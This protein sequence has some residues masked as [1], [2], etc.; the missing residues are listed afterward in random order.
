MDSPNSVKHIAI[1]VFGVW[2]HT[3]PATGFAVHLIEACK[4]VTITLLTFGSMFDK[5]LNELKKLGTP[6]QALVSR[7]NVIDISGTD[8]NFSG[9]Q[10][11][12]EPV[13]KTLW[14][15]GSVT[16]LSSGKTI[17]GLPKPCLTILGVS[18]IQ[19]L[20][21]A[22]RIAGK[23]YPILLWMP[24]TARMMLRW[25]GP[26][27]LGGMGNLSEK[28]KA[29]ASM[30][31]ATLIDAAVENYYSTEEKVVQVP[32]MPAMYAYEFLATQTT[33]APREFLVKII[34][35]NQG[36]FADVQGVVCNTASVLERD[37]IVSLSNWCKE[38][39]IGF[40]PI[41]PMLCQPG[42]SNRAVG[43]QAAD[44]VFYFLD[45]MRSRFGDKSVIYISFGS[46]FWPSQPEKFWNAID[47]LISSGTPFVLAYSGMLADVSEQRKQMI[48][49]SQFGF[50]LQWAPQ[51]EILSHPATGWFLN[52][53][54]WN[55]I[56][57]TVLAG[58]PLILWP[59]DGDQ[60]SNAAAMSLLQ[61][62]AIE[63]VEVR[64][65][66]SGMKTPYRFVAP[67]Y[68]K[69]LERQGYTSAPT[70]T[71]EASR[72]EFRRVL[73]LVK[74]E[75]GQILREN[76][77]KLSNEMRSLWSP[78]GESRIMLNEIIQTYL[79]L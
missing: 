23:E 75:E 76:M 39:G 14:S 4:D 78:E 56:Q 36:V 72:Q 58:V 52:H 65:S 6:Q 5:V 57:E 35:E 13:F 51:Q 10:S 22:R 32:G 17:S 33:K 42:P 60:P 11:D 71:L 61:Q 38:L 26:V 49:D 29:R 59:F 21:A 31:G 19:A 34:M 50:V 30:T 77:E 15:S 20:K 74:T 44:E 25:Q 46:L 8:F 12:F 41:I 27:E 9:S 66:E 55:S 73:R 48:R 62:V 7:L 43:H 53:G 63:L 67:D 70:F 54:G 37:T 68:K 2:G 24:S 47:E 45:T 40:Y 64:T 79:Q 18:C 28:A 1:H 16:C 69:L 3:K